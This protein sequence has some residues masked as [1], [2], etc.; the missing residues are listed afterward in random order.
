MR[1]ETIA[2]KIIC[3][4][5]KKTLSSTILIIPYEEN[6]FPVTYEW[7]NAATGKIKNTIN[8]NKEIAVLGGPSNKTH[9][10]DTKVPHRLIL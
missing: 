3:D 10:S 6:V 7:N 8:S 9:G 4:A 5:L 2:V 1:P